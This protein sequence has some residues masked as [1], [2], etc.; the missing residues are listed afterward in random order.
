MS[1]YIESFMPGTVDTPSVAKIILPSQ[2]SFEALLSTD[3]SVQLSNRWGNLLPGVEMLS[4]IAQAVGAVN[5]PAW[6][7]ASVQGWRGTD[8]IRLNLEMF[9]VNYAPNLGYEEKLKELAKLA[10]ITESSREDISEHFTQQ[11]HG[12]YS[13]KASAFAT[14]KQHFLGNHTTTDYVADKDGN[15]NFGSDSDK[16]GALKEVGQSLWEGKGGPAGYTGTI[17]LRVGTRFELKNLLLTSI[18]ITPSVVEVCSH[19][20]NEKPKPLYYKIS[21]GVI[22]CRTALYTDVDTMFK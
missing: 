22:T 11:V 4:E 8:P 1:F 6:I 7:G 9:L 2:K 3:V 17:T 19:Y 16:Y 18:S 20:V 13:T 15:T 12:G 14:N 21:M 10:T 5:I